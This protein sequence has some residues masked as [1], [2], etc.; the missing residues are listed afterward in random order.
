[1]PV[2]LYL[3]VRPLDGRDDPAMIRHHSDDLALVMWDPRATRL[4][5][6]TWIMDN[7]EA[8]EID[9]LAFG[10]GLTWPLPDWTTEPR[11]ASLYVPPTLR[12]PGHAAIQGGDEARRRS[13]RDLA[14][15]R[16]AYRAERLG[17]VGVDLQAVDD[18]AYSGA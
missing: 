12:L 2:R 1:M 16:A 15:D 4:D 13:E 18:L 17:F 14:I 8:H 10:L 11:P 9:A 5:I 3:S 7:L 6:T